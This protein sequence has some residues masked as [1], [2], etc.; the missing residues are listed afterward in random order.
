MQKI[1]A[2]LFLV[3]AGITSLAASPQWAFRVSFKD[4]NG[5]LDINAPSSF[6]SKRAL[7]RRAR[8]GI[9]IDSLDLP[10]APRYVD[11]VLSLTGGTLHLTSKWL[12]ECVILLQDS[13]LILNI[14]NKPYVSSTTLVGY[15]PSGL[16]NKKGDIGNEELPQTTYDSSYYSTAWHQVDMVNGAC[17]HNMGYT[18]EGKLIAV[19]DLGF[20]YVNVNPGFS[21]LYNEK[22]IIDTRNFVEHNDSVY[23]IG[24]HGTECLSTIAGFLPDSFVG[25]APSAQYALYITEDTHSEQP[26]E[27]DNMI[28]GAERADSIGAD[29]ISASL[30]YFTFDS[31]VSFNNLSYPDLDGKST[32]PAKAANYAAMKG[33]VFVCAAGNE[34]AHNWHYILTPADADSSLSVGA[35]D[36]N[37]MPTTFSSFGPNASGTV[38][39]DIAVQ[40]AR[41]AAFIDSS[42]IAY[43][44]GTSYAAPQI[45]G[46]VACLL[47]YVPT[48]SP[49]LIRKA[50]DSSANHYS[51]PG[52]QDGYGLPDICKAADIL[53]AISPVYISS[54]DWAEVHPTLFSNNT[55]L[56]LTINLADEGD[57]EFL[58]TDIVGRN[59]ALDKVHIRKGRQN[60]W[61]E[62]P[63]Y[64]PEGIYL[65]TAISSDKK[66]TA[67]LVKY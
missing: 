62:I 13:S 8:Y 7:D 11:S 33:I 27:M 20:M 36:T 4:K 54:T 59:L 63:Q 26:I 12:N 17:L 48:A 21:S 41:V 58:L 47:Q 28:A 42:Q 65:F 61:V 38:K 19:L 43:L 64:L 49:Y 46:W 18:G 6:L 30:G 32:I 34:G 25:T 50:I 29:V 35:L 66:Y 57:V 53:N 1:F 16:H 60:V 14:Q 3:L 2:L 45:A 9:G 39:P 31:A 51:V 37:E 24:L 67:K 22:R 44:Q 56:H 52:A 40:G 10:V 55:K 15:Y 5:T 23:G